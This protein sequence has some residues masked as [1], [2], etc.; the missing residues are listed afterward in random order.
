M[1]PDIRCPPMREIRKPDILSY[2]RCTPMGMTTLIVQRMV[3]GEDAIIRADN[4]Q[5]LGAGGEAT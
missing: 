4:P 3:L 2:R 5:P 1:A